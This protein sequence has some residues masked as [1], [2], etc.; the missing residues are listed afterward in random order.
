MPIAVLAQSGVRGT[1]VDSGGR[2]LMGV[3]V[4][5]GSHSA[6]T[7]ST[8]AF[9]VEGLGP[10]HYV[11]GTHLPGYRVWTNEVDLSGEGPLLSQTIVAETPREFTQVCN[12]EVPPALRVELVDSI[13]GMTVEAPAT[14]A[15]ARGD[16]VVRLT[17]GVEVEEVQER[18]VIAYFGLGGPPGTY[19]L[20]VEVDGYR[21]WRRQQVEV[22]ATGCGKV[23]RTEVRALLQPLP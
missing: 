7:D 13:T 6:V 17:L 20:E 8:G 11:M 19:D 1:V 3:R 22:P 14:V 12:D 2:S 23:D 10:G 5:V 18:R 15:A 4:Y 9:R 16:S 21:P